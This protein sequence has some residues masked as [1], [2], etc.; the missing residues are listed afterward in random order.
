[1]LEALRLQ[2]DAD[3]PRNQE[4]INLLAP[5][6]CG[7]AESRVLAA[8]NGPDQ[9]GGHWPASGQRIC[10]LVSLFIAERLPDVSVAS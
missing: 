7:M 2:P 1:M 6:E 8:S 4:N 3:D 10:P 5:L 9:T